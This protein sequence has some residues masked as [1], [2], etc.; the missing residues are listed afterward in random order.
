MGL[1]EPKYSWTKNRNFLVEDTRNLAF[2]KPP[3]RLPWSSSFLF[4]SRPLLVAT[5]H[6]PWSSSFLSQV[7]L[8]FG[9]R[10]ALAELN[11]FHVRDLVCSSSEKNPSLPWLERL[12][13]LKKNLTA[14]LVGSSSVLDFSLSCVT[15]LV[16]KKILR[17]LILVVTWTRPCLSV[18]R[19]IPYRK[20]T[21]ILELCSRPDGQPQDS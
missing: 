16:E 19:L 1:S 7:P 15:R 13:W 18:K 9:N 14:N 2:A 6:L 11:G 4:F 20:N 21:R 10:P 8:I 5:D 3:S 17:R 12:V